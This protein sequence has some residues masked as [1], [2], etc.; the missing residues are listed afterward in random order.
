MTRSYYRGAAG[1]V[2][3]YDVTSRA[4][5]EG[6]A[7]WLE[8]IRALA[9]DHIEIVLVGNKIDLAEDR[10]VDTDE[11]ERFARDNSGCRERSG[12]VGERGGVDRSAGACV[13]TR[14]LHSQSTLSCRGC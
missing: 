7:R 11:G 9:S 5:F 8:D 12:Q 13:T 10:E 6:L 14:E 4:T 3:V 1:A 2:L